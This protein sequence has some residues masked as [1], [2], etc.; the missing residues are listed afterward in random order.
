M[1]VGSGATFECRVSC[2]SLGTVS[3][4]A[5]HNEVG[6]VTRETGHLLTPCPVRV[7]GLSLTLTL[8]FK[9]NPNPNLQP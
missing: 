8:A 4:N 3:G 2:N 5:L 1:R 9:P 7:R 6:E